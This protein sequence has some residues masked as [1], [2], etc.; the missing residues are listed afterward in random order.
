VYDVTRAICYLPVNM[1]GQSLRHYRIDALIGAGAMG[2]VY[3]AWDVKLKRS[4]AIKILAE[5]PSGKSRRRLLEEARAAAAL[6]HPHICTVYE[7]NETA[8][9]PFIVME[10]IDGQSLDRII[11]PVGLQVETAIR[12]AANIAAA[13]AHAH[14]KGV[15]HRDLK[16]TKLNP[17]SAV[18]LDCD[19]HS[20][21]RY[22]AHYYEAFP[23]RSTNARMAT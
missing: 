5:A 3:K 6:N 4:V 8:D 9:Q 14:D 17:G 23:C 13:L 12:Y 10:H 20:C 11:P 7:V 16:Q 18:A 2:A 15:L 21:I 22:A 1:I 19:G